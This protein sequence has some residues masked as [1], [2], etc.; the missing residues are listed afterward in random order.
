MARKPT[1]KWQPISQLALVGYFIDEA[2]RGVTEN[3]DNLKLAEDRPYALDDYTINRILQVYTQQLDDIWLYEDQLA[4][5]QEETLTADQSREVARLVT[6]V[7]KLKEALTSILAKTKAIQK[8]MR[9]AE[10]SKSD[11]QL[12]LEA[13]LREPPPRATRKRRS[14]TR[15]APKPAREKP[16]A[17]FPLPPEVTVRKK[18]LP[19]GYA[20]LFRHSTLGELGRILV[21]DHGPGQC[22]ISCEVAGDFS[23]PRTALRTE[24][25]KPLGIAIA[26]SIG[27]SRDPWYGTTPS[28]SSLSPVPREVIET[29]MMQC[30]RCDAG[31]ALLIFA[32]E[33]TDPG[34]FEDYARKMYPE[35]TRL[36]LPT[37]II[38]PD[39]GGGPLMERPAEILQVWPERGEIERL[40]PA[41]FN[42]R[43]EAL[44]AAHCA[45][46]RSRP[47]PSRRR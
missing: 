37:W 30:E 41:E 12:E 47:T 45:S 2:L 24:I 38:G 42:P 1:P 11:L 27:A 9:D 3:L 15:Q 35:Y 43:V 4:R 28:L 16:E 5:W 33:A 31:V 44:A 46:G 7:E 29:K 34:R 17:S 6:C 25:F 8:R 22:H 26:E 20:Y 14:P 40:R 36:D 13:L 23:D 39:L 21:R 10:L 32:P 18:T 19:D